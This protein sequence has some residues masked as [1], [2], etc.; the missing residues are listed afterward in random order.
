MSTTDDNNLY[1]WT[2]NHDWF[3]AQDKDHLHEVHEKYFGETMEELNG[4]HALET[5]RKVHPAEKIE[6]GISTYLGD[7]DKALPANAQIVDPLVVSATAQ[8]W[9]EQKGPGHLCSLH[10]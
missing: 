6:V 9:A 7:L 1:V 4:E 3:V 8:A 10:T 5:W 2:D